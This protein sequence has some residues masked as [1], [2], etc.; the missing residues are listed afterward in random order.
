MEEAEIKRAIEAI[1][2]AAGDPVGVDRMAIAIGAGR[3]QIEE[4][5]KALM[6]AYSF[7]RRGMR[8]IRLED[9]HVVYD[10]PSDAPEAVVTP[11]AAGGEGGRPA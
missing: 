2:F 5:L 7:E 4:N 9:G 10:G 8:I 1:L 6:D 11:R 3:D